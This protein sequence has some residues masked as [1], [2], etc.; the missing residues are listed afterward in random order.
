MYKRDKE[1]DRKYDC[2]PPPYQLDQLNKP[3]AKTD[4]PWLPKRL[5]EYRRKMHEKN[6]CE[7]AI[8]NMPNDMNAIW[9]VPFY[10]DPIPGKISKYHLNPI[11]F[12]SNVYVLA[13]RGQKPCWFYNRYPDFG[14]GYYNNMCFYCL[15]RDPYLIIEMDQTEKL[16]EYAVELDIS[17]FRYT[18]RQTEEMCIKAVK[19][20]WKNL[21]YVRNKT[22]KVQAQALKGSWKAL[23]YI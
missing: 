16:C 21:K 20:D 10:S 7:W 4:N 19:H 17:V 14:M 6:A 8:R 15:K 9:F 23:K 2:F 5:S 22:W 1:S 11:I 3:K 12:S 13:E 18:Y